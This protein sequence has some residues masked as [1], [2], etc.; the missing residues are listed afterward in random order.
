MCTVVV[1]WCQA[2]YILPL[3]VVFTPKG[4]STS[5]PSLT[6]ASYTVLGLLTIKPWSSYMLTRPNTETSVPTSSLARYSWLKKV[7][8]R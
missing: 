4:S 2:A 6:A 8:R 5:T 7:R 3:V 1:A